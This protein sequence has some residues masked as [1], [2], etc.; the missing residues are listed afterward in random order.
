MSRGC[1]PSATARTGTGPGRLGRASRGGKREGAALVRCPEHMVALAGRD[2][3]HGPGNRGRGLKG[4]VPT[5]V[6]ALTVL[7]L[8]PLLRDDFGQ[9]DH[10]QMLP[11]QVVPQVGI[12]T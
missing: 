2:S 4:R 9:A 6:V 1:A 7:A 3:A 12:L 5:G 8:D 11:R 10:Q